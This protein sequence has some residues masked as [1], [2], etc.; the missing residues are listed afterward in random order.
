[1]SIDFQ[2]LIMALQKYRNG[3]G[4]W[5]DLERATEKAGIKVSASTILR[6]ATEQTEPTTRTWE[7][8]WRAKSN[9]IPTPPW[10]TSNRNNSIFIGTDSDG[11]PEYANREDYIRGA[12]HMLEEA[13][14]PAMKLLPLFDAGAGE[15]S[16]FS[17]G[18]YPV[19]ESGDYVT[20]PDE[21]L[22][23]HS[24]AVKIHGDSMSPY[25][26][27][28]DIA[29]V[30]PS[31]PLQNGKLCFAT[32]F[33]DEVGDRLVKRYYKYGD[34]VVLKSDNQ[35]HEDIVLDENNGTV[36]KLFR[37]TKSIREE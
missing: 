15:P 20:I 6:T 10:I 1:M 35:A 32:W 2:P 11:S 24:F 8:L 37:V 16:S 36:V 13:D 23:E 34:T 27:E 30:V 21:G 33:H 25:L 26:N 19:G 5:A 22:D 12:F 9:I 29:I 28:G 14:F 31:A 18:G 4:A 7:A 17:D 3:G